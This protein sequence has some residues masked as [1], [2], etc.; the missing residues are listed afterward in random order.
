M[1]K[2][3]PTTID[4]YIAAAPAAGQ[5]HLRKLHALLKAAAPKAQQ[6]I[7]WNMPFF[8]EP[9][10][11]FSFSAHKAH[12]DFAPTAALL[13]R[14]VDAGELDGYDST[15]HMLKVRYDQ[16]LPEALIRRMA[17]ERVKEL[18]TRKDDSFW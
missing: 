8:I 11:L 12:L 10:F 9:R 6:A 4:E 2:K 7:K 1:A 16:P 14:Y 17:K 3:K 13:Q 5:P 18:Q 15:K